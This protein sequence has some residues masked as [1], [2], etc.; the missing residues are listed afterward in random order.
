MTVCHELRNPIHILKSSIG[1][2]LNDATVAADGMTGTEGAAIDPGVARD[3][4]SAIDRME[5]TVNDVLDFRKLDA[6]VFQMSRKLVM[7]SE[8]IGDVCRHCRAFLAR[9]VEFAYRVTPSTAR[10]MVDSR[11]IFQIITNGLR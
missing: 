4:L 7:L 11:R 1:M 2:L 10:V 9:G 5:G 8:L 3:I 6:N